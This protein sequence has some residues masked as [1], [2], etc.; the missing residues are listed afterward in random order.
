VALRGFTVD[1]ALSR[2]RI[3]PTYKYLELA[4]TG[5]AGRNVL[6]Y[7]TG[8]TPK[9]LNIDSTYIDFITNKPVL[10]VNSPNPAYFEGGDVLPRALGIN[11]N[12]TQNFTR[13]SPLINYDVLDFTTT[14]PSKFGAYTGEYHK[15]NANNGSVI[16][17]SETAVF[18][19]A[20]NQGMFRK[21]EDG[22]TSLLFY[23]TGSN[24]P[25]NTWDFTGTLTGN[26][27]LNQTLTDFTF[28]K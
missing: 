11:T 2:F 19:P 27:G 18:E 20:T 26:N 4:Q 24:T 22:F 1:E 17:N 6:I 28:A 8:F 15:L 3:N 9:F 12:T 16:Y 10:S 25:A 23:A 14:N 13:F 21:D 5:T 7:N